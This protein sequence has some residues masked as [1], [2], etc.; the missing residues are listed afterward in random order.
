M[1]EPVNENDRRGIIKIAPIT[2]TDAELVAG[3]LAASL[4]KPVWT[5][6]D[7]ATFIHQPGVHGFTAIY[8]GYP[9]GVLLYRQVLAE[10][11]I[12]TLGV[13][14]EFQRRGI[15]TALMAEA[16]INIETTGGTKVFLEVAVNNKSAEKL[17][18]N[19]GYISINTRHNYYQVDDYFINAE[20]FCK[21]FIKKSKKS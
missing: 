14:K 11:E 17:Y 8:E 21:S 7:I 6:R 16:H 5:A 15:A 10:A 18:K 20:V 3:I 19:L 2:P 13:A 1:S 9:A 12:L 4:V